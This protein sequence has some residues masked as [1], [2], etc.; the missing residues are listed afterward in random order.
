LGCNFLERLGD[1]F[2]EFSKH[3]GTADYA[4]LR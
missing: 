3:D 4:D 2:F 1:L